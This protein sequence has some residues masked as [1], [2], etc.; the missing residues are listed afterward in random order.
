MRMGLVAFVLQWFLKVCSRTNVVPRVR[1]CS[2][3][4][5]TC[6]VELARAK[7][8]AN[9]SNFTCSSRV[10]RPHTQFTCVTCS[11]PVKTDKNTCFYSSSTSCRVHPNT[12]GILPV[13]LHAELMQICPRLAC[14]IACFCW[15]KYIQFAGKNTGISRR[16]NCQT[17]SKITANAGKNTRT[18]AGKNTRNCT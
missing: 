3:F 15:Q 1:S 4:Y 2:E 6:T 7:L 8:P 10:K 9:A 17:Q 16:I 5:N 12:T 13:I 11:L 18:I 14:K